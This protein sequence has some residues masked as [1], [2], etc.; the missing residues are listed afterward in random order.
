MESRWDGLEPQNMRTLLLVHKR[1]KANESQSKPEEITKKLRNKKF[2]LVFL[3]V[4]SPKRSK[5]NR[6]LK[7]EDATTQAGI[8]QL[9]KTNLSLLC[10]KLMILHVRLK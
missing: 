6:T 2:N 8:N 10:A 9:F 7:L 1:C 4:K 5:N 3:D